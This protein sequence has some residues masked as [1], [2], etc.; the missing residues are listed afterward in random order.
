MC[1]SI[2]EPTQQPGIISHVQTRGSDLAVNVKKVGENFFFQV[3]WLNPG[4][5]DRQVSVSSIP[6]FDCS[7]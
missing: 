7:L 4:C 1:T 2:R 3:L 5:Q 6:G